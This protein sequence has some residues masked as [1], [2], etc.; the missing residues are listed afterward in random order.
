MRTIDDLPTW[1][2]DYR[3]G[4][5]HKPLDPG[6][7]VKFAGSSPGLFSA[8]K[9][10]GYSLPI[11]STLSRILLARGQCQS[12]IHHVEHDSVNKQDILYLQRSD[13]LLNCL[14]QLPDDH[15]WRTLISDED[16]WDTSFPARDR[17]GR[18][19]CQAWIEYLAM[20]M[21]ME[22]EKHEKG[23]PALRTMFNTYLACCEQFQPWLRRLVPL[24]DAT[25]L[26]YKT[27]REL[28]TAAYDDSLHFSQVMDQ[29][30]VVN[31][32]ALH[33]K[34]W[35]CIYAHMTQRNLFITSDGRIAKGST[36][37]QENDEVWLLHGA[38]V[39]YILRP[40]KDR[41][42]EFV[43]EAYVHGIM[44]GEAFDESEEAST[45]VAI[46]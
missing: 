23:V 19:L 29:K 25:S 9:E 10:Y 3:A 24:L 43:G 40:V 26:S 14:R 28:I 37:I 22:Q 36:S 2:P 46:I 27:L 12:T 33:D 15:Y 7:R 17:S 11:S 21:R 35:D 44:Q 18:Y 38:T 5:I 16:I 6:G 4:R 1:V 13:A 39:P 20:F 32:R 31:V 8:T 34:V 41:K 30:D 42:Y 45:T